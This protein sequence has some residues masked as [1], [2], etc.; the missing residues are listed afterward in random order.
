MTVLRRFQLE[1]LSQR[2][3]F[4]FLDAIHT[5]LHTATQQIPDHGAL[6]NLVMSTLGSAIT[7]IM[8]SWLLKVSDLLIE[9]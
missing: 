4:K 7:E 6:N 5:E 9:S 3:K 2:K 8:M 1:S